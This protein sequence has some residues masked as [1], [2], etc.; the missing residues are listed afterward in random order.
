MRQNIPSEEKGF[1]K[2]INTIENIYKYIIK[3]LVVTQ[4][5]KMYY[6]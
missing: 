6:L 2:Y 5:V 3:V 1:K 4:I